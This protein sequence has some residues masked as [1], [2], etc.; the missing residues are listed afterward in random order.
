M[1]RVLLA[2]AVA[3]CSK[4]GAPDVSVWDRVAG[5]QP[6]QH[7]EGACPTEPAKVVVVEERLLGKLRAGRDH[8]KELQLANLRPQLDPFGISSNV[9][10]QVLASAQGEPLPA[11]PALDA[12]QHGKYLAYVRVLDAKGDA[13][14]AELRIWEPATK[15]TLCGATVRGNPAEARA[16]VTRTLHDIAPS[17]ELVAD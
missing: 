13:F 12:A 5:M 1:K 2:C 8:A 15:R 9:F 16:A 7:A 6:A 11:S 17:F 14:R 3:A 10:W 4:S